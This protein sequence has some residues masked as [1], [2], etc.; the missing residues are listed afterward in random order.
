ML[1]LLT[2]V[3]LFAAYVAAPAAL[4]PALGGEPGLAPQARQAPPALVVRAPKIH[5]GDGRVVEGGA[6]VVSGGK[7]QAVGADVAVPQGA[8]V[9]E[10]DGPVTAGFVL[11][12]SHLVPRGEAF[13]ATRTALPEA[14]LATAFRASWPDLEDALH[15]GVTSVVIAPTPQNVVGG[16]AAV[17]KTAGGRVLEPASHLTLSLSRLAADDTR[18]PTSYAGLVREIERHLAGRQGV[19]AR[20]AEGKLP[21][22][23]TANDRHEVV[24][25]VELAG[26]TGL[27]GA[28]VGAPLAGELLD[29][30]APSKLGVVIDAPGAGTS[31]RVREA[32]VALARSE[33]PFALRWS[34]AENLRTG[35]A[36]LLRGGA[37]RARLERALMADGARLAGVAGKVG[38]LERGAD[39]DFVLWSG[40][41][42]EFGSR[43]VAVYI[44]GQRIEGGKR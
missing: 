35:L 15:A 21:V 5:L 39:A 36:A 13:D 26:R 14:R 11:A 32:H 42:F 28:I 4:A 43:V 16:Q 37:E 3:A 22:L 25:A 9:L 24:R 34:E 1:S 30:L 7:V 19:F 12:H 31:Q 44:D 41:P 6:L 27:V 8:R 20:V 10:H 18:P 29:V 23:V 33:I 17:V 40:D 38:L 2:P